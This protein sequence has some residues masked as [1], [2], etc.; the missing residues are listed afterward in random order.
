[1]DKVIKRK[2]VFETIAFGLV[3]P[4]VKEFSDI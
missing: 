1:M 3:W 4:G 2:V